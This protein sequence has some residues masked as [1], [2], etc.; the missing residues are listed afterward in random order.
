MSLRPLGVVKGIIESAGMG[1]SYAYEDLIFVDHNAFLLQFTDSAEEVL[2]HINA[3]ADMSELQDDI[4]QLKQI[5]LEHDLLFR[6]GATYRMTQADDE[7]IR[8][9]FSS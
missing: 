4:A 8:I 5:A 3:E 1:V 9:E 7:N 2:I 6:D